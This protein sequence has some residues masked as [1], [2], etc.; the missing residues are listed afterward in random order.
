M[1]Y[2]YEVPSIMDLKLGIKKSKKSNAKFAISST[3]TY[4]FRING[5]MVALKK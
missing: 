4:K 1:T 2:G 3:N 5:E